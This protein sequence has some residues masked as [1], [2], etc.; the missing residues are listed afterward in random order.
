MLSPILPLHCN[1]DPLCSHYTAVPGNSKNTNQV[2]SLKTITTNCRGPCYN[3]RLV[4]FALYLASNKWQKMTILS[5]HYSNNVGLV[6]WNLIKP[7]EKGKDLT[8]TAQSTSSLLSNDPASL[9]YETGEGEGHRLM[10]LGASQSSIGPGC[11]RV[12]SQISFNQTK[13]FRGGAGD[14]RPAP[15][16]SLIYSAVG[17]WC[18]CWHLAGGEETPWTLQLLPQIN[19]HTASISWMN[20]PLSGK[21]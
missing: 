6:A 11:L 8:L 3:G 5:L 14:F 7:W 21:H 10:T 15:K 1:Y 12:I 17:L 13:L 4:C 18:S 19:L 20:Y 2:S 16:T 9:C